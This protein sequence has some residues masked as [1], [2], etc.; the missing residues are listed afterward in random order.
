MFNI[1]DHKENANQSH[2]DSTSLLLEWSLPRTQNKQVQWF[3]FV[4][5]E[6]WKQMSRRSQF[7]ANPGQQ[8]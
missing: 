3:M 2:I 7:K 5:L 6:L 8:F 1:P 4:I